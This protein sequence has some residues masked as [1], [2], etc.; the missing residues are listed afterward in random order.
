MKRDLSLHGLVAGLF[1]ILLL[2]ACGINTPQEEGLHPVPPASMFVEQAGDF[3]SHA[4]GDKFAVGYYGSSPLDTLVYLYIVCHEKDTVYRAS[5]PGEW[6]VDDTTATSDTAKV[7]QVH[8]KMRALAAGK[9][10]PP[11]DSFDIAAAAGQPLFGVHLPGHVQSIVYF[12]AADKKVHA[13]D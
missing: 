3:C 10:M 13:L 11:Q 1:L 12:S 8:T 9:L 6:F 7:A 2:N 4:G 5:Y